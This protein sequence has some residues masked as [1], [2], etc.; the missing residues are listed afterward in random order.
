M[1]DLSKVLVVDDDPDIR[2]LVSRFLAA[3]GFICETASDGNKALDM[4]DNFN[5][6][7]VITDLKMPGIDGIALTKELIKRH[8][9]IS[10]MVMT[11]F[12]KEY[13]EEDALYAGARDF[14]T[15]PFNL[16]ELSVR[17]FKMI[18]DNKERDQLEEM[19]HLDTLTGL[20]NRKLFYDRLTQA[21][22][23]AKRYPRLFALL[24]LDLDNFKAINDTMGHDVGDL[25]LKEAA[26][27]LLRSIRRSETVARMGGD[28]FTIILVHIDHEYEAAVVAKRIIESF[29]EP[30]IILDKECSVGI[31]IGISLYPSDGSDV[32]TLL[33]KADAAMYRVKAKGRNDFRFYSLDNANIRKLS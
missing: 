20:P 11:G 24:Y 32:E 13:S 22:E 5:F 21:I 9:G 17:F 4:A 25:L 30:F 18:R 31:S 33:K 16:S 12:T 28:E 15:K 7:A 29:S 2:G 1:K 23:M 8:P 27:R 6:D 10:I 14:I 19:A 26:Q 3:K